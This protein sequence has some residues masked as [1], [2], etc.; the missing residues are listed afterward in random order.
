MEKVA[1]VDFNGEAMCFV[2]V[3]LGDCLLDGYKIITF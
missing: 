3:P 1:L 2:H